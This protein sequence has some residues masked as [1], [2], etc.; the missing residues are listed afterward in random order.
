VIFMRTTL[1]VLA[2]VFALTAAADATTSPTPS[3][4]RTTPPQA[5]LTGTWR[6]TPEELPLTTDF[7]VSV[8]GTNARSIRSVEMSVRPGGDATVVV[9]RKV[10]DARGRTIKGSESIEEARLQLNA[11][12]AVPASYA[13]ERHEVPVT[14]TTAERRYPDDPEARWPLDGLKVSVARFTD[15][16]ESVEI[17]FDTPEGR[18]SFWETL[19]RAASRTTRPVARRGQP[20][21]TP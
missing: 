6:S 19:R 3:T 17:R 10:V 1:C 18:G 5:A 2:A 14:V 15:N 12:A 11:D 7:D 20:S 13:P 9:T 4:S 8:W 16:P 21:S